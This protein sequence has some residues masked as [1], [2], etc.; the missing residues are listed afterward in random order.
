MGLPTT[1]YL[2]RHA[3]SQPSRNVEESAWPLSAPGHEEA[4]ALADCLIDVKP[5]T[6]VSS[7]Y[8]RATQ[9]VMPLAKRL[10]LAIHVIDDLRE[11]NVSD[12]LIDDFLCEMERSW[13]DFDYALPGCESNK[14]AQKRVTRAMASVVGANVGTTVIVS[15]HG[16]LIAL[17]LNHA[18]QSFGYLDWSRM[19]NPDVFRFTWESDTFVWDRAYR[20]TDA[21]A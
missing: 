16:N 6:I 3:T 18:E 15:S 14:E 5:S 17:F 2:V 10:G 20:W 9:T 19:Q 13:R 7:P 1:L 8:L 12:G 21:C 4:R 11:R